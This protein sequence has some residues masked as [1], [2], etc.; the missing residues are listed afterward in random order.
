MVQFQYK[1]LLLKGSGGCGR[2]GITLQTDDNAGDIGGSFK[3]YKTLLYEYKCLK[4]ELKN[5]IFPYHLV[6]WWV[7]V[8]LFCN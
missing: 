3:P 4:M 2:C 8:I 7:G 5:F 1:G 6:D